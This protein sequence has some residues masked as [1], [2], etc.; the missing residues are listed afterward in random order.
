MDH[1]F[2]LREGTMPVYS[3]RDAPTFAQPDSPQEHPQYHFVS[4]DATIEG[5]DGEINVVDHLKKQGDL[6]HIHPSRLEDLLDG[7]ADQA[8]DAINAGEADDLL[9][10]V[11]FAEREHDDR[12]TVVQAI[13]ERNDELETQEAQQENLGA[14]A[15]A[16][17]G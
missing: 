9:D 2:K 12:A 17:V 7:P 3:L 6:Q 16:D 14:L 11:L 5:R 1:L 13:A 10:C 8:I 4:E 15:P